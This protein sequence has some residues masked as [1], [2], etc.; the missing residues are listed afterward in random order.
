MLAETIGL[1][2]QN[3]IY[4]SQLQKE[5]EYIREFLN[6]NNLKIETRDEWF[7]KISKEEEIK[8]IEKT[9]NELAKLQAKAKFENEASKQEK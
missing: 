2:Q 3:R 8:L 1:A 5:F 9:D 4:I 7:A 6:K